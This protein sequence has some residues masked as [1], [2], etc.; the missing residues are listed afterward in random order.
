ML[1]I[2][3]QNLKNRLNNNS[4]GLVGAFNSICE[5]GLCIAEYS[6]SQ[7]TAVS[8]EP[9]ISKLELPPEI[10]NSKT[11]VPWSLRISRSPI[12]L[13]FVRGNEPGNRYTV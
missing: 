1:E 12:Y 5:L 13:D 2:S 4:G 9:E 3:E 8:Q 6:Q 10:T 11:Y 7:R